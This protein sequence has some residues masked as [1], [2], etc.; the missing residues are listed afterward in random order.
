ML[1]R[2]KLQ[3]CLNIYLKFMPCMLHL[4]L[5]LIQAITQT[6]IAVLMI[7][8]LFCLSSWRSSLRDAARRR[9]QS[10]S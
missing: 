5:E 1:D 2:Y 10:L 6:S 9:W 3:K 7:Y 8:E 4:R